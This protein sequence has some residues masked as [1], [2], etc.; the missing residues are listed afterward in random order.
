[1]EMQDDYDCLGSMYDCEAMFL[2]ALVM[3]AQRAIDQ[4]V[5]KP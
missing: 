2:S 5:W 1:M 3:R 4:E